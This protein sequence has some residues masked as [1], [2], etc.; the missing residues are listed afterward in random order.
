MAV[1]VIG[2]ASHNPISAAT[3]T[4][5]FTHTIDSGTTLT[6]LSVSIEG[7]NS[8]L[9]APIWDEATANEVFTLLNDSGVQSASDVRTYVYGIVSATAKTATIKVRTTSAEDPWWCVAR[10]YQ[11]TVI[12]SVAA[13]ML[14]I[15][16]DVNTLGTSTQAV[17]ASGGTSG[18]ALVCVGAAQGADMSPVSQ[19]VG[20]TF[21]EVYDTTT[22]AD[23]VLDFAVYYGELL[24]SAPSAITLDW[25]TQDQNTTTFFQIVA[26]ASGITPAVAYHHYTK[27]LG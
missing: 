2:A 10:N 8:M 27:N 19:S 6:V 17:H 9:A 23:N 21:T 14:H 24:N 12:S 13:A 11:G 15:T 16:D 22:G 4:G 1:S 25:T 3:G 20:T 5:D 18:N 7:D 26:L